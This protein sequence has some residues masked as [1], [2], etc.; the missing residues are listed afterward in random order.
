[1]EPVVRGRP[2][3]V[4]VHY[5][6]V[7]DRNSLVCIVKIAPSMPNFL[8]WLRRLF[9][10][11]LGIS[12]VRFASSSTATAFVV[13]QHECDQMKA[14]RAS[15]LDAGSHRVE[16][17]PHHAGNNAFSFA[18]HHIVCLSL[19]KMP[20]ELWNRRGVASSV[21][22]FAGLINVEHASIHGH[23]FAGIF[24]LAKV[25][26]LSHIPHHIAFHKINGSGAYAD[27]Y[28]NEVWD[29]ARSLGN[30]AAPPSDGQPPSGGRARSP[31]RGRPGASS[32]GG[33][34]YRRASRGLPAAAERAF[35]AYN[36]PMTASFGDFLALLK[37]SGKPALKRPSSVGTLDASD[38]D[39]DS[40]KDGHV[41][42]Q[43][44]AAPIAGPHA[45]TFFDVDK[46]A[47]FF[48]LELSPARVVE[49]AVTVGP[50]RL[51]DGYF[52]VFD[53]TTGMQSRESCNSLLFRFWPKLFNSDSSPSSP[54]LTCGRSLPLLPS[55]DC[56]FPSKANVPA[57]LFGHVGPSISLAS[58]N[59]GNAITPL[60]PPSPPPST[61]FLQLQYQLWLTSPPICLLP[62]PPYTLATPPT[63][64]ESAASPFAG[65]PLFHAYCY[66]LPASIARYTC[67]CRA[68][69]E[70]PKA[71]QVKSFPALLP[72]F[73]APRVEAPVENS[74]EHPI[75]LDSPEEPAGEDGHGGS[76][77]LV[78]QLGA[79][80]T[81]SLAVPAGSQGH[82]VELPAA[83]AARVAQAPVLPR[84]SPRLLGLLDG[85]RVDCIERAT[86]RKARMT[87]SSSSGSSSGR[88][89][90]HSASSKRA[91]KLCKV[92]SLIQLPLKGTPRP[93]GRNKLKA[94]AECC[95][96]DAEGIS[97]EAEALSSASTADSPVRSLDLNE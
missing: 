94:F 76:Q 47:F 23:D 93:L 69:P 30:P 2:T 11:H 88:S 26:A 39:A 97:R 3:Y 82:E 16:I 81:A 20:L 53:I 90:G 25:E 22:G 18:Y 10:Q 92:S 41:K 44:I 4:D 56:R 13:F 34:V 17:M 58:S 35:R 14:L 50:A 55:V 65:T 72:L 43:L 40:E 75:R 27:V 52:P 59:N 63:H 33:R 64:T 62:P 57:S 49:G 61:A 91:K 96:L 36:H 31:P 68:P 84:R 51:D 5:P 8:S 24:V 70:E 21:S 85:P 1:M 19:E 48:R 77:D 7:H 73:P 80:G 9:H 42:R 74:A 60:P 37:L 66:S 71:A 86:K 79:A 12:V 38:F 78:V 46:T 67:G 87:I 32:A 6:F 54:E 29:V 15:P 45:V 83:T 89:S 95:D 28:I